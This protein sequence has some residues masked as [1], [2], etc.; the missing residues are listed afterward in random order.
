MKHIRTLTNTQT[1][2]NGWTEGFS[3]IQR[4][5]MLGNAVT[6]DIVK[7]VGMKILQEV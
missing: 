5:K 1:L 4:Y 7:M 6:V 2:A 3:D